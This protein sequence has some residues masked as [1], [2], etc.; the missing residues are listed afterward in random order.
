ECEAELI[1]KEREL[2]QKKFE[3]EKKKEQLTNL[4]DQSEITNKPEIRIKKEKK[5]VQTTFF[6]PIVLKERAVNENI[7]ELIRKIEDIDINSMTPIDAMKKLIELKEKT[8]N[9]S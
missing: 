3:V 6:K 9:I 8:R 1:K 5:I 2:G 7:E 4:K